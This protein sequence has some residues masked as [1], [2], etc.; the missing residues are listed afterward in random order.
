MRRNREARM[1]R[2]SAVEL[3]EFQPEVRAAVDSLSV[4]Q[5]AVILLTYWA[6]LD[7]GMVAETLGI[8]DGAV[9]RQLARGRARLREAL[10]D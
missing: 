2:G 9:R 7:T 10:G 1:D 6:D 3:P 8:S 4:Q 5:R